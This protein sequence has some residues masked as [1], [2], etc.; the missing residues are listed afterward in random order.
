MINL[1]YSPQ[2]FYGK[3]IFIDI[4]SLIVLALISFFAFKYYKFNKEKKNHIYLCI[5]FGLISLSFLFKIMT[6]FSLYSIERHTAIIGAL[7]FTYNQIHYTNTSFLGGTLIYRLLTIVGL[8]SLYLLYYPK[9]RKSSILLLSYFILVTVYFTQFA[10]YPFHITAFLLLILLAWHCYQNYRVTKDR[11]ALL[12]FS[13]FSIIALSQILA[14]FL[15]MT[16]TFYVVSEIVQLLGYSLL[17]SAFL[18][19][20]YY[21]T[22]KNKN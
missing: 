22:K 18:M 7:A 13:S 4:I 12:I 15:M 6:N 8:F 21:G 2:W 19:V 14:V 20:L 3:D 17:L 10:F 1:I 9:Q 5:S 11:P 16:K